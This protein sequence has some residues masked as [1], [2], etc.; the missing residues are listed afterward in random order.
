MLSD[1]AGSPRYTDL[2]DQYVLE[3]LL[4]RIHR[5]DLRPGQV[6]PSQERLMRDYGVSRARVRRAIEALR[7]SGLVE[8]VPG[9]GTRVTPAPPPAGD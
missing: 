8:S 6:I 2:V 3:D 1:R 9:R 5:G 4:A 7:Q